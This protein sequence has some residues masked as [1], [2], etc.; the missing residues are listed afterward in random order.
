M[1][2]DLRFKEQMNVVGHHT[3]GIELILTMFV[4]VKN[5]F[6][7]KIALGRSELTAFTRG[8]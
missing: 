2:L 5:T 7:D 4:R 8:K 1:L 6:E 3:G